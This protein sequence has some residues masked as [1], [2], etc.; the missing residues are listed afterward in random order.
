MKRA[1]NSTIPKLGPGEYRPDVAFRRVEDLPKPKIIKEKRNF[2]HQPCPRCGKQAYRDQVYVRTLHDVGDLASGRPHE[3][4]VTY[5]Q[6]YCSVCRKYFNADL[7]DLVP[8]GGHYTH[9]VMAL[10]VRLVVEDGLPYRSASWHLWRDHRVF[11]PFAT[12]QNWVEAGGEKGQPAHGNGLPGLGAGRR[13][14][15]PGRR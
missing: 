15:L 8:P 4:H 7:S 9:R 3:L 6:H 1:K 13:L 10:A 5:S 14:R 11:V 12:I 2:A